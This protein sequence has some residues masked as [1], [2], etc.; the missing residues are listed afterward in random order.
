MPEI[1]PEMIAVCG[2]DCYSCD[3]RKVTI[4][5]ES[6]RRVVA[7][8]KD[9]EWLQ[10]HEGLDEVIERSMY[11]HG[12]HGDRT[13]HWAADCWILK[14]CVD[15]KGLT[16]CSQCDIFPCEKLIEWSQQNQRYT[17]ALEKLKRMASGA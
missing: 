2:L 17:Q 7:W 16:H 12:C 8:F 13:V 1:S 15:D 10:P 6:A 14:C 11:C 3:I 9:M 4:D 5:P